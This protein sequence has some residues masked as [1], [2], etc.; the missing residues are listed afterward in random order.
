MNKTGLLVAG[1]VLTGAFVGSHFFYF[2]EMF[3]AL[4]IFAVI[5]LPLLVLAFAFALLEA[6]SE[7][8]MT[9]TEARTEASVVSLRHLVQQSRQRFSSFHHAA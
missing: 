6:G 5:A 7:R 2:E 1:T 3:S 9:W 8:A 4:L